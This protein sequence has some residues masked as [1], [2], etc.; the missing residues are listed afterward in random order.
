MFYIPRASLQHEESVNL[1]PHVHM[2]L[3]LHPISN[4]LPTG[5]QP[6]WRWHPMVSL[7]LARL[8]PWSQGFAT[9]HSPASFPGRPLSRGVPL[10]SYSRQVDFISLVPLRDLWMTPSLTSTMRTICPGRPYASDIKALKIMGILKPL[11]H[12]KVVILKSCQIIKK[13]Y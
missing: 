10:F 7:Y 5:G 1:G 12:V 8:S 13:C 11:Y 9:R 3:T 4:F 2:L 6:T